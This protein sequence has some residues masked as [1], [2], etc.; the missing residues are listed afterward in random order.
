MSTNDSKVAGGIARSFATKTLL[1]ADRSASPTT[2]TVQSPPTNTVN[3]YRTTSGARTFAT[4][5]KT[6][7]LFSAK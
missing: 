5:R 7:P 2:L 4:A 1:V 3:T 6:H